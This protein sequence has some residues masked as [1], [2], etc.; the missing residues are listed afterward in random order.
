MSFLS[1]GA[2]LFA[3]SVDYTN[4]TQARQ[5]EFGPRQ[6]PSHLVEYAAYELV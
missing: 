3:T 5:D 4:G 1:T 2:P 6:M